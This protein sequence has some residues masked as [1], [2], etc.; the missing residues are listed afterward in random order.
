M[1]ELGDVEKENIHGVVNLFSLAVDATGT[2]DS[3]KHYTGYTNN[4][5]MHPWPQQ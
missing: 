2:N 4:K 1:C 3:G 5:R